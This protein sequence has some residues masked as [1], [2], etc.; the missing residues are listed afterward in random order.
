[1]LP[2]GSCKRPGFSC[3]DPEPTFTPSLTGAG[4]GW[5][6]LVWVQPLG[7]EGLGFDCHR[8]L[9]LSE[10]QFPHL[11]SGAITGPAL[12]AVVKMKEDNIGQMLRVNSQNRSVF[13]DPPPLLPGQGRALPAQGDLPAGPGRLPQ[14]CSWTHRSPMAPWHCPRP[15]GGWIRLQG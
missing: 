9:N 4:V 6:S 13:S 14:R 3:C 7:E 8:S 1:M 2:A 10:P 15:E 12:Q 11:Q 5:Q